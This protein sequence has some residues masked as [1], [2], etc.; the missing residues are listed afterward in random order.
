M[1]AEPRLDSRFSLPLMPR[2]PNDL[3]SPFPF[4]QQLGNKLRRILQV[5]RQCSNA[6]TPRPT[7][8][9]GQCSV[10]AKISG[11]PNT[12]DPRIPLRKTEINANVSSREW[13]STM[14][15]SQSISTGSNVLHSRS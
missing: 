6:V 11:E 14:S 1:R 10:G 13:S 3:H 2:R 15:H 7:Y 8:A 5:G 4:G 9:T 12:F